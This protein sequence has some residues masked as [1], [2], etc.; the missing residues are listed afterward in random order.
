MF[1]H[2]PEL[3]IVLVVALVVFGPEKLPEVAANVGKTMRDMRK[4]FEEAMNPEDHRVPDDFETYYHES[5]ERSGEDVPVAAEHDD[6][7]WDQLLPDEERAKLQAERAK[8]EHHVD[9]SPSVRS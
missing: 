3:L 8:V 5:M 6:S 2:L 1:G 9:E 4:T 7:E